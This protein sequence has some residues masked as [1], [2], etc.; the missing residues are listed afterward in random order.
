MW[1]PHTQAVYMQGGYLVASSEQQASEFPKTNESWCQDM[2]TN[3]G[4]KKKVSFN[5]QVHWWQIHRT[6]RFIL[7]MA[8]ACIHVILGK[9]LY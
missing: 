1:G 9:L 7:Q 6:W 5:G 8:Q 2:S 3:T 4:E